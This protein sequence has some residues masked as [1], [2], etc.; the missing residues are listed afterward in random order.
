MR[1]VRDESRI[2]SQFLARA[3]AGEMLISLTEGSKTKGRT[4][5][6]KNCHVSLGHGEFLVPVGWMKSCTELG[7]S[8]TE[9]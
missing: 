8:G 6:S 3:T 2:I 9:E 4:L 7:G 5:K 1:H